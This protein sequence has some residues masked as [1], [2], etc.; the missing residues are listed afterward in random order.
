M[1]MKNCGKT[2]ED[3]LQNR[4]TAYITS[5]VQRRRRDYMIQLAKSQEMMVLIEEIQP[6]MTVQVEED[7][8]GNLPFLM[9]LQNDRLLLALQALGERELYVLL[10][11]ALGDKD[12]TV[13]AHELQ[14]TYK[15][16]A[17]IYY[18]ALK[19]VRKHIKGV[20]T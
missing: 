19:K 9:R 7:A 6:D 1:W 13:L 3:V 8:L 11:Y 20:S 2:E 18:R 5:A 16:V 14:M 17:A 12:L 4:F 15:G 10:N